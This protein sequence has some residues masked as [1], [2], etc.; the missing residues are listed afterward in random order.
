MKTAVIA[1]SKL[2][3]KNCANFINGKCQGEARC[4][5]FNCTINKGL[6]CP[7][8]EVSVLPVDEALLEAYSVTY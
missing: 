6:R 1:C 2:A 4:H 5:V 8:F 7:F 3:E